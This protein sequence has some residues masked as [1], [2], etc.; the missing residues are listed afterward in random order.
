MFPLGSRLTGDIP[1]QNALPS[2]M[3]CP[4]PS[5]RGR[6]IKVLPSPQNKQRKCI[7][8]A[9]PQTEC[10]SWSG[11]HHGIPQMKADFNE[12][13]ASQAASSCSVRAAEGTSH[14]RLRTQKNAVA[15]RS[16]QAFLCHSNRAPVV[17]PKNCSL[18]PRDDWL[19][20]V[21]SDGMSGSGGRWGWGGGQPATWP[22]GWLWGSQPEKRA[23]PR[24]ADKLSL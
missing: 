23:A 15:G 5:K 1:T 16:Y 20:G 14:L 4:L 21:G 8:R 18:F 3:W 10:A 22:D 13:C 17:S 12:H 24:S 9:Q 11:S 7:R 2:T 19:L 6:L